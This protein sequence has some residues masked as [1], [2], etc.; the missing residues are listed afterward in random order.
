MTEEQSFQVVLEIPEGLRPFACG[1]NEYIWNAAEANGITLPAICHQ[2]RCLTCAGRLL[3]GT[4]DHDHPD[5]YFPEDKA[6][7]YV[8][9]CRAMPRSD[10]RIRTHQQWKMRE[11]R[12]ARGL[13]AP[14]A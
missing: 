1:E 10:V 13:P 12:L 2:G 4:V 3:E 9:L 11:F 7:G 5:M 6:E 8:L 14:Y